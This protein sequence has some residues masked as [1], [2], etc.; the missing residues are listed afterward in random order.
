MHACPAGHVPQSTTWPH[1]FTTTP[2]VSPS[3][4]H[5]FAGTTHCLVVVSQMC[6]ASQPPQSI[7][8]PHP[9]G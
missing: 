4:A 7:A 3:C 2:H 8:L 9:S 6:V 1:W 5:V